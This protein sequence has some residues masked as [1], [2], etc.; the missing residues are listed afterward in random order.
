MM[1]SEEFKSPQ[2]RSARFRKSK[3]AQCN[4]YQE[5]CLNDEIREGIWRLSCRQ[6]VVQGQSLQELGYWNGICIIL[7]L[8]RYSIPLPQ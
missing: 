5:W 8:V 7:F 4:D 1:E 6:P 2:R 3:A